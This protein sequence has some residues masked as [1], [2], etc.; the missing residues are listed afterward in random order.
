MENKSREEK[1]EEFFKSGKNCS[2]SVF[3]AFA[4]ILTVGFFSLA[5]LGIAAYTTILVHREKKE[6]KQIDKQEEMED[7][8]DSQD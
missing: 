2:Q 4:D 1:A 6:Q 7:P 5:A 8:N 3:L